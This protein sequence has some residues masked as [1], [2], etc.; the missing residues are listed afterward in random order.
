MHII[1]NSNKFYSAIAKIYNV[2][3][4]LVGYKL[5]VHYFVN[6][7]PFKQNTKITVLDAGCG[8]G[9]YTFA[10]L[11]KFPYALVTAF[12]LN[13]N[14]I[15]IMKNTVQKKGLQNQ[16]RIFN[17]DISKP[18]PYLD[19]QQFDLIITGGVLEYVDID[20]AIKNLLP[21]LKTGGYFL[22]SSVKNNL[23]GKIV[24]KLGKFKT[25]SHASNVTA[26]IKNGFIL[27]RMGSFPMSK[28]VHLFLK[29]S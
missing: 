1:S 16:V 2:L 23:A 24:A 8:T 6:L 3:S 21:Y 29:M 9:F 22:N 17:G 12:D 5:A 19:K 7:I 28:E 20:I 11:K 13:V 4:Q 15:E 14:M 10:V 18:L 26:F 27:K 25:R